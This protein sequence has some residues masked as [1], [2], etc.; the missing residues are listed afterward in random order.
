MQDKKLVSLC[1]FTPL[2]IFMK[3]D[4]QMVWFKAEMLLIFAQVENNHGTVSVI[5]I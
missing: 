3:K 4:L 5:E 2:I 1:A